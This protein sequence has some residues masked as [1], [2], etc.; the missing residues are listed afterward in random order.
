[1]SISLSSDFR[2]PE[3]CVMRI[4]YEKLHAKKQ[5]GKYWLFYCGILGK[6]YF[7]RIPVE[8]LL[9]LA[10]AQVQ[11]E[12]NKRFVVYLDYKTGRLYHFRSH[13]ACATC[14]KSRAE[15]FDSLIVTL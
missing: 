14:I 5:R 6:V 4:P 11:E 9:N 12:E 2:Y 10:P 15:K 3:W 7:W 8:K 13:Q 1:M